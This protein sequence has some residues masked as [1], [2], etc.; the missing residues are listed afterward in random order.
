[1]TFLSDRIAAVEKQIVAFE[2]AMFALGNDN[3]QA[4]TL[5]TGQSIQKV[6]RLDIEW[7]TNVIN[8]L[9]NQ[10]TVMTARMN[11]TGATIG[12]PSW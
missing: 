8:S 6:T 12:T 7:M 11:G 1:M 3:I 5:D 2:A 10:H 4:Y 9:Y